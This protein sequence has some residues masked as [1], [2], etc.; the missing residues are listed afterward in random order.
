MY[1]FIRYFSFFV[2]PAIRKY[3]MILESQSYT[4]LQEK[5][6]YS[7]MRWRS[8]SAEEQGK[9]NDQAASMH[10]ANN[11]DLYDSVNVKQEVTKLLKRLQELV[12]VLRRYI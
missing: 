2:Y 10:G 8:L 6:V 7:A 12:C 4:S 11:E 5:N 1:A 3:C 9:Y